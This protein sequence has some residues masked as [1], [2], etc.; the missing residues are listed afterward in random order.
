MEL[1][2]ITVA[3]RPRGVWE[4]LDLGFALARAWFPTLWALWWLSALP[5]ALLAL[6]LTG[7]RADWWGILVWWCKPL[8]EVPLVW[9]ISRAL[10]G[11][12]TPLRS[13]PGLLRAAWTRRLIP[14]LLWRRLTARRSFTLP[15]GLLEGLDG[16]ALGQRRQLLSVGAGAGWLTVICYHFE[17][18]LWGGQLLSL[19][20]LIP[21]GLA[22]LDLEAALTDSQSWPYWVSGGCY[23]LACS[24]IAPFYVCAGFTLYIGRRTE[25]E[26]WD[27][28]LAFR[29]G[30]ATGAS[31]T[32]APWRPKADSRRTVALAGLL[33]A[34]LLLAWPG[35][36]AF[37]QAAP[38]PLPEPTA[39]RALITE[40]LAD[41]TFGRTRQSSV[42]TYI[43]DE[44]ADEEPSAPRWLDGLGDL[45]VILGRVFKTLLVVLAV[46]ALAL[47]IQRILR[48]WQPG[49]WRRRARPAT[50]PREAVTS[51]GGEADPSTANL[52]QAVRAR[53]AAA[54]P[55]GALALLYRG[56]IAHLRSRGVAIP[57]AA[58]EGECLR[59]ATDHLGAA[60]AAPFR[61]LTR[62]WQALAYAQHTPEPQTIA[63]RLTDW[64]HWTGAADGS[65]S[66]DHAG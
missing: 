19:Y 48:D 12:R 50:R 33:C 32:G 30:R 39:A 28:E 4:R 35:P 49:T 29:Q 8:C 11:E 53:L 37:A 57:D 47:L 55:R 5:I 38:P 17:A 21:N 42:W 6:L 60:D 52:A 65:E 16:K 31:G 7:A 41:E 66:T 58:T 63:A 46:A 40:V 44:A 59:L 62:D 26:A 3:L 25:L 22:G 10:F 13:A 45:A 27:L 14:Y 9:W 15:I 23:L 43:G 18:I 36:P 54:D 2:R 24:V 56:A 51:L 64:L 34:A 1:D 20:Y 61:Y